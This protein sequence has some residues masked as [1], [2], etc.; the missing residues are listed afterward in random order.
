MRLLFGLLGLKGYK[1]FKPFGSVSEQ[2]YIRF[3]RERPW[4]ASLLP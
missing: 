3:L 1:R 4:E 2:R